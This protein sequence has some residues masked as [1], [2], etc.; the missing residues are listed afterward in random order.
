MIGLTIGAEDDETEL[1]DNYVSSLQA[2]VTIEDDTVFGTLEYVSDY[3]GFSNDVNLQSGHFLALKF[4]TEPEDAVTTIELVGGVSGPVTL[5]NDKNA[6]IRIEDAESQTIR[7]VSSMDGYTTT[8]RELA[9]T[10]L[11][12][13]DP[14]QP[15]DGTEEGAAP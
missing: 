2:D 5:D 1:F 10:G 7:I 15:Q 8:V 12:L 11:S 3:T 13:L 9:L 6:V 14:P 4:T